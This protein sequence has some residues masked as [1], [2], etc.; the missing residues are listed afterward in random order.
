ML[1]RFDSAQSITPGTASG[2]I[3][4]NTEGGF[5]CAVSL[6][7]VI[8]PVVSAVMN[9][10]RIYAQIWL[11]NV[12]TPVQTPLFILA[13]GYMGED[14]SIGW[15]GHLPLTPSDYVLTRFTSPDTV[16]CQLSIG[17]ER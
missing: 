1:Y 3:R 2:I 7:E 10:A 15:T 17:V 12:D 14:I 8:V 5:L 9:G 11:S 13:Q 4:M 6:H 16:T